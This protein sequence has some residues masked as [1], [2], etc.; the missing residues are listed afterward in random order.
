[1]IPKI[2]HQIQIGS[3]NYPEQCL[4]SWAKDYVSSNPSY[5]YFLWND[6]KINKLLEFNQTIK[7]IY[8]S[9]S[10]LTQKS[11]IA[12]YLILYYFGGLYID[13]SY[14]W[15]SS[16][17]ISLD[18]LLNQSTDFVM[19]NVNVFGSTQFNE[20]IRIIL[21]QLETRGKKSI[22]I[23]NQKND[24]SK[25]ILGCLKPEGT[26]LDF[27]PDLESAQKEF[28]KYNGGRYATVLVD[29]KDIS[30]I[31]SY[32]NQEKYVNDLIQFIKNFYS[33]AEFSV[34]KFMSKYTMSELDKIVE[35]LDGATDSREYDMVIE[36]AKMIKG[37][38]GLTCEI[39]VR[40]GGCSFKV[41][42][43]LFENDDKRPHLGIDP[44]GNIDYSHWENKTEKLD[45]TNQMK[46]RMQKNIYLWCHLVGYEFLFFP[47]EDTEFFNRYSDG[48]PI[49]NEVKRIINQ[50][51]LI[52]FD[53]PH[54]TDLV[55]IEFDFFKDKVPVGGV[56]IFDDIKQYPHMEKLDP[57]IQSCGYELVKSGDY[58]ACYRKK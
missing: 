12:R 52:I 1:M 29:K 33:I 41:M 22:D 54:T 40:E 51:A 25:Y 14:V 13:I 11:V 43:T 34:D 58:K 24:S 8:H 5:S 35:I 6:E 38:P 46:L 9:E 15:N 55:K 28:G 44:Y 21:S 3:Q 53:G 7:K 47:L 30:L 50:Y 23:F 56:L 48:I 18:E 37:V 16:T 27:F 45:Y 57:Y 19:G 2:I 49:Y 32:S 26:Y 10:D 4:T 42:K 31:T 17:N 36:M 39:G 20:K